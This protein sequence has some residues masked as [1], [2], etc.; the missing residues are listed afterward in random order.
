MT[1]DG[2]DNAHIGDD[3]QDVSSAAADGDD[4]SDS[5]DRTE[6]DDGNFINDDGH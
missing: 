5:D 1:N 4:D 6:D 3:G 2:N